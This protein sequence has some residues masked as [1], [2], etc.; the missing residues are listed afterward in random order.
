[1]H[2]SALAAAV[3]A[4]THPQAQASSAVVLKNAKTMTHAEHSD[5][6]DPA[7]LL[8]RAG[9]N[10]KPA[11][12][13]AT[14]QK[15]RRLAMPPVDVETELGRLLWRRAAPG[16]QEGPR[17]ERDH[18]SGDESPDVRPVRD[19]GRLIAHRDRA[20]PVDE[21]EERPD[22]DHEDGRHRPKCEEVPQ[23]EKHANL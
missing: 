5:L 18:E 7:E 1:Q 20:Q 3:Q 22:A 13:P 11:V 19:T 14:A 23:R 16:V 2:R 17:Q 21:L 8:A 12:Q 15:P 9:M 10:G 4:R 6:V